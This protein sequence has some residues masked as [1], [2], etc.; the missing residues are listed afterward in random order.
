MRQEFPKPV[1]REALRR[2]G[3]E[4]EAV[5]PMYGWP[6][7]KKCSASLT[8][9]VH[10]D[11]VNPDGNGGKPTLENCAAVCPACHGYKTKDDVARIAK[12][13]RQRDRNQGITRR[14][15]PPMP[16]SKASGIRKRMDGSVERW[17]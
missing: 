14:K 4:C 1:K 15:G 17:S 8:H 3:F 9:G 11:H 16:G 2:S 5:G 6:Q 13:K 12:M 7:G 10:F